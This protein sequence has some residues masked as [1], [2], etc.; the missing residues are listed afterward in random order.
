M[1]QSGTENLE[2]ALQEAATGDV[3]SATTTTEEA[4]TTEQ[5]AGASEDSDTEKP[6]TI[7][8]DRFKEVNDRAKAATEQLGDYETKLSESNETVSRLSQLLEAAKVDQDMITQIREMHHDPDHAPHVEYINNI[9]LGIENEVE[10]GDI[11]PEEADE[12]ARTLL[13]KNQD[14]LAAEIAETREQQIVTKADMIA[15]KWLSQLPRLI[16]F[17]YHSNNIT[18]DGKNVDRCF[19]S[20]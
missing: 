15:D 17:Q 12:K 10:Q 7:P 16:V 4:E 11:T 20:A 13:A 9:L 1:A 14:K 19:S 8:Y 18:N 2:A 3:E 6:N 5:T